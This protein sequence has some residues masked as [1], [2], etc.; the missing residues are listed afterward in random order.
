[1]IETITLTETGCYLDNHRGHYIIRDTIELAAHWGF[2]VGPFERFALDHYDDLGHEE[3]Y[4]QECL[5]E[6]CDEAVAWLNAGREERMPGQNFPPIVPDGF[7]W[8]FEDGDFGLWQ[9]D[10]DGEVVYP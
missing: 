6:L 4:P 8:S 7:H 3:D 10:E 1:M 2:I 5:I 9:Y